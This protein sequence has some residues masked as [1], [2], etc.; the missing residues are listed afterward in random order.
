VHP[1]WSIVALLVCT[2]ASL[3][4]FWA[5]LTNRFFSG[6]VRI[7]TERNHVVVEDGPYR[8]VRHPGY[9]GALL[10]TMASPV[11]LGSW[12][13]LIPAA[14]TSAVLVLR[15]AFE[16]A[17]LRAELNGYGAYARRVSARL[18]PRIW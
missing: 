16:D 1:G 12:Y 2:L 3:L 5:M 13:A 10:F 8:Y 6:T 7:Q 15:T 11:A 4:V 9:S 14:L 18:V 17:T